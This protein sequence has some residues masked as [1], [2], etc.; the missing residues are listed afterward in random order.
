MNANEQ[1]T[2]AH[3]IKMAI[4]VIQITAPW[5]GALVGS[6]LVVLSETL[7]SAPVERQRLVQRIGV[8]LTGVSVGFLALRVPG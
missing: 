8:I 7:T 5:V 1:L 4:V 6:A 2:I 3:L